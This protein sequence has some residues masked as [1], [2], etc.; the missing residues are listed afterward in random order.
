LGV[1]DPPGDFHDDVEVSREESLIVNPVI[2]FGCVGGC[3]ASRCSPQP[4]HQEN[5][6]LVDG[7]ITMGMSVHGRARVESG[8]IYRPWITEGV[9]AN[10]PSFEA[11]DFIGGPVAA[12]PLPLV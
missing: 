1:E 4:T 10:E 2:M 11:Y 12:P 6:R 9:T 7:R 5:H 3:G 8:P